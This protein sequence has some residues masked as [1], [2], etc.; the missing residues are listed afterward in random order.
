MILLAILFLFK[1]SLDRIE[2]KEDLEEMMKFEEDE[3]GEDD[4]SGAASEDKR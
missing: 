1:C 3:Q 2:M 4:S